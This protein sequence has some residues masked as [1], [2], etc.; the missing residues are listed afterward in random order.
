M[1][2]L[3]ASIFIADAQVAWQLPLYRRPAIYLAPA[4]CNP[5]QT[6]SIAWIWE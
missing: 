6:T 4:P 5:G 1:A 3:L 2:M